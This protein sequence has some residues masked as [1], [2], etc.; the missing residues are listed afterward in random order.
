MAYLLTHF[1]PGG[2]E[3]QYRATLA[4]VTEAAGGRRPEL[5]HAAGATEGGFLVAVVYDSKQTAARRRS[6]GPRS[7]TRR[8]WPA[9]PAGLAGTGGLTRH[10]ASAHPPT[11][12]VTA[13]VS[14]V[15]RGGRF[16]RGAN[17]SCA[18]RP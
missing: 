11:S 8:D 13:V 14:F 16:N 15:Y 3:E 12:T 17:A 6:A 1:W 9:K 4:A 10:S 5:V 2:T 18:G 7:S